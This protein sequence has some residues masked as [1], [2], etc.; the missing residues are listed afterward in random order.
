M[1]K[2]IYCIFLA[3]AVVFAGCRKKEEVEPPII[4]PTAKADETAARNELN[5]AYDDVETV[6]NSQEYSDAS[7]ARTSGE[8]LPCGKVTFSTKNFKIDYGQSGINC[9]MKVISGSIDVTLV[10]GTSFK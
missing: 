9:G 10:E 3:A 5:S 8:V 4:T 2:S 1:K 7:G 6:Y